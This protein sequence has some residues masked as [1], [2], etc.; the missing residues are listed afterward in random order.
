MRRLNMEAHVK[1]QR[2]AERTRVLGGRISAK[3]CHPSD[4]PTV[5]GRSSIPG[6]G[7]GLT[8]RSII[9]PRTKID[10]CFTW[11]LPKRDIKH[12]T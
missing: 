5:S 3:R 2:L 9:D 11:E 10:D 7:L 4:R 8:A 12:V 1:V 6:R